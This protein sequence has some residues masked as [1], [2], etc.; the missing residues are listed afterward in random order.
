MFGRKRKRGADDTEAVAATAV[1][2]VVD[3]KKSKSKEAENP[4]V[5]HGRNQDDR[6]MNLAKAKHNWQ[7][8][9]CM[10]SALLAISIAFNGYALLKPK[11]QPYLM[12]M[13]QIGHV[14]VVGPVDASNPVDSKRVI[15]GQTIEWVERSR[16]VI[17]DLTAAKQNVEWVYAR[18]G[19][20]S[21][22]KKK[23]DEYFRQREPYKTAASS[24]ATATITLALQTG[25]T[26]ELEWT[27]EWRNLQGDLLRKERWKARVTF[28][29]EA[30]N[31]EMRIRRNPVGYFVTDF[32]WS[33]QSGI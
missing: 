19:A 21:A 30:Q 25:N 31:D 3:A 13:D 6:Y 16:A 23:L 20:N 26:Y 15:R 17:G 24:S 27:E 11:F 12:A 14:V 10:Q 2:V 1:S 5:N 4:Y 9:F 18:V 7:V 32:S 22:A 29:V 8:A 28:A 33:K